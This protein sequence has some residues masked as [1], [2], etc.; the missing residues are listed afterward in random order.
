VPT[1]VPAKSK[2]TILH[3]PRLKE[4]LWLIHGFSTR[5]GGSSRLYGGHALNLGFTK[6]D[7]RTAIERNRSAF[8]AQLGA[9]GRHPW[10]LV[11]LRQ[12]HSDIIHAITAVPNEP[13][14]GDGLI[15]NTPG[16]LLAI[17]TA[18]CLPVI[19]VDR[20]QRAIGVFHAGWRGTVKRIVEKGVGEMHRYFGSRPGDLEAAIGPGVHNC[21]YTVGEEVRENFE[22]QFGYGSALF[23]EVKESDPVREKYPMLFLTARAP[24]HSN[25]PIK[26]FLDL[27]EA[28]RRQLLDAGVPKKNIDASPLCTS[29]NVDLLFSYRAEK[30]VTGRLMGV[31]GI[32]PEPARGKGSA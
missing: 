1:P 17:Q 4:I 23:H 21:C 12:I 18:D 25:L 26:I 10:P 15:T 24:G 32:K 11:T 9:G 20:R 5:R 6:T 13:P 22:S 29:C 3:A 19:V 14:A 31:A 27:V 8:L 28:N 16:L 2:L 7:H 30:G